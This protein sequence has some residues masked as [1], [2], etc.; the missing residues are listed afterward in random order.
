M[1]L[2]LV[3]LASV[4]TTVGA[5]RS[6][7]DRALVLAKKMAAEDVTV[8]VF[9]EQLVGGYPQEDLVLWQGFVDAQWSGL[10]RFA[11]QTAALQ[12][13]FVLGVSIAQ[14]GRRYNCAA[15]VAGGRILG[16]VPKQRLPTYGIFY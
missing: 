10:E 5:V 8:G 6:N 2:V 3:A 12:T 11:S 16:L 1:R 7:V 9:Q 13:V 4:N 15:V 14:Q